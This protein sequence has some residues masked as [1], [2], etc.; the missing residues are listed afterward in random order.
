[1]Y[2]IFAEASKDYWWTPFVKRGFGHV[3]VVES[4]CAD[5][6]W[7]ITDPVQSHTDSFTWP[8]SMEPTVEGL[9]GD[10][11]RIVEVNPIIDINVSCFTLSLNTCVDTVKR[12]LG[13]KSAFIITPYQ[14]Y[15]NLTRGIPD[16]R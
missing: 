9:V 16:G 2:V 3:F 10:V 5:H 11:T 6:F 1:M 13:I 8:K 7:L 15:N 14:L 4:V 12:I